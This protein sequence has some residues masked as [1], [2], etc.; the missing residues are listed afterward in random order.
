MDH[1]FI[2]VGELAQRAGVTVRTLH[3]WD[4]LGLLVPAR[5]TATGHRLYGPA[6][7][8]RLQRI[9]S[10]RALG[11]SLEDIGSY[12]KDPSNTLERVLRLHRKHVWKQAQRMNQLIHR[13]DWILGRLTHDRS[14]PEDELLKTME[15]MTMIE[16]HF[17]GEQLEALAE[18]RKTLG[19]E[20]IAEVQEEWPRLI[21][22]VREEMTRGTDPTA[23][24]V[25][26]LAERW[27]ELI[28]AFSGGDAGIEASVGRM[29]RGNP[30]VAAEQ[31]LDTD[32]FTYIGRAMADL[33]LPPASNP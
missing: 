5:R 17:T 3:H 15:E 12:L 8:D 22:R 7:I 9:R 6:E 33:D 4:H 10:L 25:R 1:S 16:Q 32:L 24:E 28:T 20:A 23:P 2:R 18:R 11:L 19:E 14:V 30:D 21:A 27:R 29:Y 26:A 13:L 31:G